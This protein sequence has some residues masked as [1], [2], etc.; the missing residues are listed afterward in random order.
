MAGV[1]GVGD[2]RARRGDGA[3][4][5]F[6]YSYWDRGERVPLYFC[7]KSKVIHLSHRVEDRY[8][9]QGGDLYPEEDRKAA[10]GVEVEEPF[11]ARGL[12]ITTYRYKESDRTKPAGNVHVRVEPAMPLTTGSTREG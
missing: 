1:V 10:F 3:R 5:R 12:M 9:E 2:D 11:S 8:R 4:A 7:G 6:L